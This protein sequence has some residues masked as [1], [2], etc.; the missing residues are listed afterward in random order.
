MPNIGRSVNAFLH[1]YMP[2]WPYLLLRQETLP[3]CFKE[4]DRV[5]SIRAITTEIA[6]YNP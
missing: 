4:L 6:T 1:E 5:L 2:D 3:Q